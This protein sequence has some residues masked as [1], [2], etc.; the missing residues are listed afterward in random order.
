MKPKILISDDLDENSL[1]LIN[2]LTQELLEA[3]SKNVCK[4]AFTD[5]NI[6]SVAL[7][8]ALGITIRSL[9]SEEYHDLA[10][11]LVFIEINKIRKQ[12]VICD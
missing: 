6:A 4:K 11:Q 2:E 3:I 9:L 7:C 8:R 1:N 12:N 10:L 5:Y